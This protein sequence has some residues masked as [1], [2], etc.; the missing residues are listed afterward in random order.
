M[1]FLDGGAN[2]KLPITPSAKRMGCTSLGILT[3]GLDDEDDDFSWE[4]RVSVVRSRLLREDDE[5]NEELH[6]LRDGVL[7]LLREDDESDEELQEPRQGVLLE[8]DE[9]GEVLRELRE[10]VLLLLREDD[11]S[12]EELRES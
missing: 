1:A 9:S 4:L 8:D 6:E 10:N 5:S 3:D 2:K 7:L 12:G 11:E